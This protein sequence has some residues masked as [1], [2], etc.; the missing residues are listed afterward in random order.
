MRLLPPRFK[1]RGFYLPWFGAGGGSPPATDPYIS[2]VI[3][4]THFDVEATGAFTQTIGP[5]A[6][7]NGGGNAALDTGQ[8][9]FG[10]GSAGL[11]TADINATTNA[12]YTIGSADF[13]MEF[14]VRP[15]SVSGAQVYFDG[16]PG[17]DGAYPA[18]YASGA[19]L[20]YYVSAGNQISASG[21]MSA[22]TWQYIC[23]ARTSGTTRMY[24]GVL[25]GGTAAKVGS[26]YSDGTTYLQMP[27]RL[28]R[29]VFASGQFAGN[30]DDFRLTIGHGRGYT[31]S[32][33]P[34]PTAAFPDT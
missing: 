3:Q 24:V 16:R 8:K 14:W 32:S 33:I 11:S 19:D 23:V 34:V 9:A 6:F 25:G 7:A 26:D 10:I 4:L 27:L 22:T 12:A 31:G 5:N 20:F 29:S 18:I 28:G 13:A 1:Q 21:A 30:F 2:Y 15:S 17:S